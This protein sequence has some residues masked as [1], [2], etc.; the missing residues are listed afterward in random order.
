MQQS[1]HAVPSDGSNVPN[2]CTPACDPFLKWAGGKRWLMY[3]YRYLFPSNYRNY[4]E[5]FLGSGAAYFALQPASAIISDANADLINTY[6]SIRSDPLGVMDR[7]TAHHLSHNPEHYYMVR[8][9]K[10]DTDTDRAADF[11]YLNRTCWNGLYRVNKQG[12]FNVPIG[13]KERVLLPS[14]DFMAVSKALSGASIRCSD[15]ED[16]INSAGRG[17][18]IFVDPPYT[19]MHDN[20]GFVKYNENIFM[21]SD[22]CRLA[23]AVKSASKR[24]AMVLMTNANHYSIRDLYQESMN[25]TE[26]HRNSVISGSNC[27]RVKATE[28]VIRNYL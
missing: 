24:G 4:F 20:N 28:L 7:L 1:S 23:D 27:G 26:V 3:R 9:R 14:D 22:Q 17:D 13:T 15:F 19:V 25:I 16:T 10:R 5:P 12:Q 2:C 11:I 18:F 6:T 8:S 21:W